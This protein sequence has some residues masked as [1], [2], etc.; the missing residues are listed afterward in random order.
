[1]KKL[2]INNLQERINS[3]PLQIIQQKRVDKVVQKKGVQELKQLSDNDLIQELSNLIENW[4]DMR[5]SPASRLVHAL[6]SRARAVEDTIG[7]QA[8]EV[9]WGRKR[10]AEKC[11]ALIR[12]R[13]SNGLDNVS[14]TQL[15]EVM[16]FRV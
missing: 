9:W 1:M 2:N 4:S 12:V 13:E 11:L 6:A 3:S 16:R 8:A 10:A 7:K 14:S 5:I 15:E